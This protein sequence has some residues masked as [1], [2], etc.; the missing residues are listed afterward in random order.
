VCLRA[1]LLATALAGACVTPALAADATLAE[2]AASPHRTPT[3]V[4]RD[5][6]RHPVEELGFFGIQPTMT[7]LELWP[8]PGYWTEMLGPYLAAHGRYIVA[9]APRDD[10]EGSAGYKSWSERVGKQKSRMGK[11]TETTLGNDKYELAP[12]GTVDLVLT[13]RNLHN[14]MD[15]GDADKVLAACFRALKPGGILGVED[16]RG[17]NDRPQDPKAPGGY[18]REDYAIDLARHAGFELVGKSEVNANPKD[19]KQWPEGVWTLPPSF[20]L[21]AKDHDKYAAIGEAD[22]FVLKLRKPLH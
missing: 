8:E 14:W 9:L 2:V 12:A 21:G 6:A 11:I 16:H 18:V 22:N 1:T 5:A 17:R 4:A 20:A 7:V 15:S 3:M 13:F 10:A 19:T